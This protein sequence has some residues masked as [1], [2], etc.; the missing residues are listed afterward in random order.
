VTVVI[1]TVVPVPVHAALG[2]SMYVTVP[3]ALN[4]FVR[5]AESWTDEPTVTGDRETVVVK[6]G[7]A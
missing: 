5:L 6:V 7:L 4:A 2:K 1:E 3:P